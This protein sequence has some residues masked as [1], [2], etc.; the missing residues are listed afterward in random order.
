MP[1]R[2][3]SSATTQGQGVNTTKNVEITPILAVATII[4]G[5]SRMGLD[6]TT[7]TD[8]TCAVGVAAY[9]WWPKVWAWRQRMVAM[10][11]AGEVFSWAKRGS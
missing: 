1:Q 6:P 10:N 2:R 3:T 8:L 7:W 9:L 5:L 4:F 11:E